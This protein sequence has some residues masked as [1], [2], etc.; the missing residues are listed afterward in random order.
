V[1]QTDRPIWPAQQVRSLQN[2]LFPASPKNES[3]DVETT[4]PPYF[5]S[6]H[7]VARYYFHECDRYLRYTATPK[8]QRADEGVP[9]H[10]LDH[11]LLTKA[12]LDSGYSWCW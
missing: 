6:P 5:L 11:S 7:R 12:I 10:E 3:I 9:P 1:T 2:R 4:M 8:A